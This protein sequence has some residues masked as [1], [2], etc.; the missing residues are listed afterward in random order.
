MRDPR[1]VALG[2]GHGLS[3]SLKALRHV[4]E[5]LTA[6]V[7]VADDGGSS[8]RL[9]EELHCLPPGDLR[10]ALAALCDDTEWG[11][12]W[13]KVLQKRFE[14]D[15]PLDHHA[16]GNLLIAGL[17]EMFPDPVIGLDYVAKLLNAKGRVLPM[18]T[19]PLTVGADVESAGGIKQEIIGQSKVAKCGQH[20][21]HLWL[22]PANPPAA[23]EALAAIRQA[24]W[25]VLGPGSWYTSVIV[26]LLVPELA[27]AVIATPAKRLVTL[28]LAPDTET[29]DLSIDDYLTVLQD[30]APGLWIDAILVDPTAITAYHPAQTAHNNAARSADGSAVRSAGSTTFNTADDAQAA[31]ESAAARLGADLYIRD[32]ATANGSAHHDSV[33]LAIA[34]REIMSA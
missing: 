5:N 26:N 33:K 2:G 22:D 6:I 31:L 16:I 18:S 34:Y 25:V 27:E 3:A 12:T 24:D 15:G 17:W 30:H 23:P 29:D 32:V 20:I 4:T 21:D 1:V 28:N 19:V 10:M 14:S 7:T 11:N 8:G 9:R 13:S